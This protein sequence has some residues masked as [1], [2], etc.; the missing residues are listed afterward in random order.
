MAPINGKSEQL[1][2]TR[3]LPVDA[4]AENADPSKML[5]LD[6]A[7]VAEMHTLKGF[8]G[9]QVV[10]AQPQQTL[11][12]EQSVSGTAAVAVWIGF[13]NCY[14][15][16]KASCGNCLCFGE[17]DNLGRYLSDRCVGLC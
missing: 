9:G 3:Y 13:S 11:E 12:A 15:C 4:S 10:L 7:A 17:R 5:R 6:K 1:I 14:S 2:L 16:K 8:A